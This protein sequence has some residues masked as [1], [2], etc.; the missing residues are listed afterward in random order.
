MMILWTPAQ[1]RN[2]ILNVARTLNRRD[3]DYP[4]SLFDEANGR[5]W[6]AAGQPDDLPGSEWWAWE[7]E[8]QR[9]IER[10]WRA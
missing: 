10:W 6:N 8:A 1:R 3:H 5:A 2:P 7:N 4:A 9:F